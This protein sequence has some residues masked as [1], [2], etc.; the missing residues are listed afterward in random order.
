MN[1][2]PNPLIDQLASELAPVT[3]L[4]W[5]AGLA[6]IALAMAVSVGAV[7]LWFGAWMAAFHGAASPLFWIANGLLL[8]LGSASA[9]SV[10]AMAG[11]GVGNRHDAPKWAL[12]AVAVLP[13]AAIA[14][15]LSEGSSHGLIGD[16]HGI[17][18]MLKALGVGGFTATAMIWWL[19]R[20]APVSINAAGTYAGLA[21]GAL[22]SAAYGISCPLDGAVHLGVWH[23]APVVIAGLL[24][25]F[26]L[27]ALIRW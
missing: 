24:G 20:G 1:R 12:L 4:R 25:R 21:A 10:V 15:L 7:L 14:A 5:K 11:P 8:V 22:G 18:C 9:I 3:P 17:E 6:W 27:P 26:A 2:L 23:V 19:R 16:S 13:A